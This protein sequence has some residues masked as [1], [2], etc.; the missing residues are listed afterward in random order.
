MYGLFDIHICGFP[1]FGIDHIDVVPPGDGAGILFYFI[2]VKDQD[3]R[4]SHRRL[5]IAAYIDQ[6]FSCRVHA[7]GR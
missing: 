7:T 3:Q 2:G 5:I 1:F 6:L 4:A